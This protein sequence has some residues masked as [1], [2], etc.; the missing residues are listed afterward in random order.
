MDYK[1]REY[2]FICFNNKVYQL[3]NG[4]VLWVIRA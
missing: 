2:D 4:K 3:R 1:E